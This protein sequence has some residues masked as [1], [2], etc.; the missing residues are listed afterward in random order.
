MTIGM[1][2]LAAMLVL[3]GVSVLAW[4]RHRVVGGKVWAFRVAPLGVAAFH[5]FGNARAM[6]FGILCLTLVA[7]AV[8]AYRGGW[9]LVSP[10]NR[11][12]RAVWWLTHV[13]VYYVMALAVCGGAAGIVRTVVRFSPLATESDWPWVGG[14][15]TVEL[16]FAVEY[17]RAWTFCAEHDKRLRFRSGKRIGLLIDTCGYGPFRVY[18]MQDGLYCLEDG[19]GLVNDSRFFR[20][21]VAKETVEM[22]Q[23]MGWFPIPEKGYV[24]GWC[25]GDDD[26]D[27]FSF[28]IYGVG[29]PDGEG[30]SKPVKGTPVGNSLDGMELIGEI[31]TD[32]RFRSSREPNPR[33]DK[34]VAPRTGAVWEGCAPAMWRKEQG[35]L[36]TPAGC[37]RIFTNHTW[38][39]IN[40]VGGRLE[41]RGRGEAVSRLDRRCESRVTRRVCS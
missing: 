3:T 11:W 21:N 9:R 30:W 20:V 39:G 10:K 7:Y 35:R 32:D 5:C 26:L 34:S 12:L 6:A 28:N 16:P 13:L 19:Y 18:R 17:K 36:G 27:G 14:K 33:G 23:G 41:G 4:R 25:G 8:A 15:I 22:K 1:G 29:D 24:C 38:T 2:D 40:G 31:R 37:P